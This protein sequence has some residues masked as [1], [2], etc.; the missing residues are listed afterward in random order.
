VLSTIRSAIG[1]EWDALFAL[2]VV[3]GCIPSDMAV[4]SC[5]QIE[6]LSPIRRD[7]ARQTAP[8][9]GAPMRLFRGH[10][11]SAWRRL[12]LI[13]GPPAPFRTAFS[14]SSSGEP[15]AE[16]LLRQSRQ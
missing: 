16:P 9:S 6:T 11:Q 12:H 10:Q 4:D 5:E 7:D 14:T 8:P 2:N 3:D 13:D 15:M 1:E